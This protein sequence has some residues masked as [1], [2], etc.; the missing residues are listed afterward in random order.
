MKTFTS[1]FL[2]SKVMRAGVLLALGTTAVAT[3]A[4]SKEGQRQYK[5]GGSFIGE[6]ARSGG[7]LWSAFQ[8]PLDPAG[9]T[10]ALRVNMIS[11]GPDIAALLAYAGADTFGEGIGQAEM[12]SNDTAKSFGVFYGLKQGNP[13]EVKAIM[14]FEGTIRFTSPNTYDAGGTTS[15][16][17][18]ATDGDGDGRPDPGSTPF[19]VATGPLG[20]T[21]MAP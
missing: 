8:A 2:Q 14:V 21:R 17:L 12:I 18:A 15:F 1:K 4:W 9:K 6:P 7:I 11:W 3:I 16:Y 19:Y 20:A 13:P 5:L 10:A